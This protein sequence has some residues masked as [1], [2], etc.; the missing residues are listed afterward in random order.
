MCSSDLT[1]RTGYIS[2]VRNLARNVAREYLAQRQR[3]EYPLIKDERLRRELL[4]AQEV[5]G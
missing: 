4:Q 1:E 5:Q 2:R 3:L